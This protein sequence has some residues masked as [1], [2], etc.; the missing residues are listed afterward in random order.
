MGASQCSQSW[1]A[2]GT[3]DLLQ[4]T[5]GIREHIVVPKSEHAITFGVQPGGA[6]RILFPPFVMLA[7]IDLDDLLRSEA[8]EVR[9]VRPKRDLLAKVMAVD[10][11]R[12]EF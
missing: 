7:A 1:Q 9:H 5:G 10:L 8:A 11:A 3:D 6:A 4:H 12:T 2:K